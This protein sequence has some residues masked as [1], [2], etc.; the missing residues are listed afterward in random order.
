MNI[1]FLVY[2]YISS[3]PF[4]FFEQ[5][6]YFV[7]RHFVPTG[8]RSEEAI[9]L[10]AVFLLSSWSFF[11]FCTLCFSFFLCTKLPKT[12]SPLFCS[13][14]LYFFPVVFQL[15][16]FVNANVLVVLAGG[17]Y[18]YVRDEPDVLNGQTRYV[19]AAGEDQLKCYVH[20]VPFQGAD[21][22][23]STYIMSI[24]E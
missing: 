7:L 17:C 12:I 8:E 1:F 3:F 14:F 19:C 13:R 5:L 18:S 10:S 2:L 16:V 21:M 24:Y 4:P 9:Y 15:H 23:W 6:R 20:L 22:A 11:F